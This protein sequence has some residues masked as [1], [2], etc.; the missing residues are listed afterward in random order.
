[1]MHFSV[2]GMSCAACSSRVEKAVRAVPGVA[3]VSVSLLTN[4]MTVE[5]SASSEEIV[6]AVQK[7][8]YQASSS[9]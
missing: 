4:S 3:S 8:G 5:G 6:L 2:S 1:M 9:D 7:A